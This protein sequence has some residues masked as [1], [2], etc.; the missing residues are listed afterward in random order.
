MCYYR[1]K[2]VILFRDGLFRG[3]HIHVF[4]PEPDLTQNDMGMIGNWNDQTS[5]IVVVEGT[6]IFYSDVNYGG[7]YWMLSLGT[8]PNLPPNQN[9]VLSSLKPQ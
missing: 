1:M 8:Y 9:D 4:Q 5:S 7:T 3:P 6:W 2:E